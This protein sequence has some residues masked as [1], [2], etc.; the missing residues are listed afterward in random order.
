MQKGKIMGLD[1]PLKVV[2]ITMHM[3]VSSEVC[4]VNSKDSICY[5]LNTKLYEDP[6]FFGEFVPDNIVEVKEL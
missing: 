3:V 2:T 4:D 5:Y 6:E 1:F